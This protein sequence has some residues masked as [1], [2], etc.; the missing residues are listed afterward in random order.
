MSQL[1]SLTFDSGIGEVTWEKT[2]EELLA[3]NGSGSL[4]D[5]MLREAEAR[6]SYIEL[7]PLFEEGT[8]AFNRIA[9]DA[10]VQ[11]HPKN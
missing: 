9:I 7:E 3:P 6:G 10:Y 5:F 11:T 2:G 4:L 8:E 1:Y